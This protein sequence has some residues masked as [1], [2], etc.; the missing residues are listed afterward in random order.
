MDRKL[1]RFDSQIK[2]SFSDVLASGSLILGEQVRKFESDFSKYL[3]GLDC[4][5]VAN[6][7][8]ALRIA[9]LSLGLSSGSKIGTVANAGFYTSTAILSIGAIPLY[10]DVDLSSSNLNAEIVNEFLNRES[11]D[12][13]VVTHLYGAAVSDIVEI[14]EVCRARGIYLI[15]DCAQSHGAQV[16]EKMVGTFGDVAAFSFYPTKNL[17]ALGDAG[18]VVSAF[19][20]ISDLARSLRTYGWADKYEVVS[21]FGTNSRMDELQAGFLS[22]FLPYLD[23]DNDRRRKIALKYNHVLA[24]KE[25]IRTPIIREQEYVAHLYVIQT[26]RRDSLIEYFRLNEVQTAIHYPLP[27]HLQPIMSKDISLPNTELLSNQILTIPCRPDFSDQEVDKVL[28]VL[29]GIDIQH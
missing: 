20:E 8:D 28:E 13:L 2:E 29:S 22:L 24:N 27:D 6:G 23:R 15:E 17:G 4:V 14:V 19:S 21:K 7:T 10:L 26:S 25:D 16:K 3:G 5:S 11:I 9:L 18:A 1:S 12:A